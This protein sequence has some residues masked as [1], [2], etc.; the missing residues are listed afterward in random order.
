MDRDWLSNRPLV[1]LLDEMLGVWRVLHHPPRLAKLLYYRPSPRLTGPSD[2]FGLEQPP[3]P[4]LRDQSLLR[5]PGQP[6]RIRDPRGRH[7]RAAIEAGRRF[8]ESAEFERFCS[9]ELV[10]AG[11]RRG[12]DPGAWEAIR[13]AAVR[14]LDVEHVSDG[15][16]FREKTLRRIPD[17]PRHRLAAARQREA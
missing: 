7:G 14:E 5:D 12:K 4:L 11:T 1:S 9:G 6:E 8:T 17:P 10:V 3:L 2:L 15:D 13:L 16:H